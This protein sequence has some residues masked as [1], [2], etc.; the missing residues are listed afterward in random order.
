MF[1]IESAVPTVAIANDLADD[2]THKQRVSFQCYV[3]KADVP[4]VAIPGWR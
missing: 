2:I 3:A 1:S 4:K